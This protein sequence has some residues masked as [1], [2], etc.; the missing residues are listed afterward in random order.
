L[1]GDVELYHNILGMAPRIVREMMARF[2]TAFA[3][4]DHA[5][6]AAALH[7]LRGMAANVGALALAESAEG[8]ERDLMGGCAGDLAGFHRII[9]ETLRAVERGLAEP[10][11]GS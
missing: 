6:A 5:S 9:E 2:N 8:L 11:N 7:G 10:R 1:S 3:A 4:G